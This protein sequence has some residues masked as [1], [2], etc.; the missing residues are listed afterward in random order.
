MV[1]DYSGET[2]LVRALKTG[3]QKGT[4]GSG[5]TANLSPSAIT[6]TASVTLTEP[7]N[8]GAP[9]Y[10][11]AAAGMTVTLP[12]AVGSE[13]V[14]QI[15]VST[16]VTSNNYVIQAAG[17]DKIYGIVTVSGTTNGS[18]IVSNNTTF[19][20]NGSTTGGLKGTNYFFT[21]MGTN[22]WM[23]EANVLGSSTVATPVSA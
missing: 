2:L 3:W 16:S 9:V 18:F 15:F 13:N 17:S 14:Y 11:S 19:T 6:Y 1:A 4:G 12:A 20:M 7:N 23:V 10:I 5:I 22:L 8:L 21:D